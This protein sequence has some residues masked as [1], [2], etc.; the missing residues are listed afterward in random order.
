MTKDIT[1]T[2]SVEVPDNA[3][4]QDITEWVNVELS[5]F[6]EM[7]QGNPCIDN[8]EVVANQWEQN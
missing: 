1:V 7:K 3:T 2:L 5:S 8:A 4:E 6:G